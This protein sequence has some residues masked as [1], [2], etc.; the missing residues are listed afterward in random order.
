MDRSP[1]LPLILNEPELID[2]TTEFLAYRSYGIFFVL[3]A[4][5]FRSLYV[6]IATPR[7]YGF[8][9][10]LMAAINIVLGYG[11]IFGNLGFPKLGIAGAGLAS[12][13]AE[14]LAL[15]FIWSYTFLKKDLVKYRLFKFTT[16]KKNLPQKYSSYHR[17][18]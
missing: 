11:M 2:A 7:I 10:F 3:I 17:R 15:L 18:S 12:S 4:T 5:A 1:L 13:I 16:F 14:L 6:G 9:S 8:Y